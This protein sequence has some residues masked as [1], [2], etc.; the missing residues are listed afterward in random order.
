MCRDVS[1]RNL[2]NPTRAPARRHTSTSIYLC[3]I[4][5]VPTAVDRTVSSTKI[6]GFFTREISIIDLHGILVTA[7]YPD[8]QVHA[9]FDAGYLT[10]APPT[11]VVP[12]VQ[13]YPMWDLDS[14]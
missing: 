14:T 7:P 9:V 1:L 5:N 10:L 8:D 2:V 12:E 13:Q 4:R 3:E 6:L 11:K